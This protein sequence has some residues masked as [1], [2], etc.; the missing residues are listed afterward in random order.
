MKFDQIKI[1]PQMERIALWAIV[2]LLVYM[3][4]FRRMSFF[5]PSAGQ[6]ISLM[7]LTE[8]SILSNDIKNRYKTSLDTAIASG[9]KLATAA[10]K[11]FMEYQDALMNVLM[12]AFNPMAAPAAPPPAAPAA[13]PPPAAPAAAPPAA[14]PPPAAPPAAV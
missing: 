12:V 5:T 11:S 2:I 6:P 7:D 8:Y 4:F 10:N 13:A 9:G 14:A 3:V 1:D